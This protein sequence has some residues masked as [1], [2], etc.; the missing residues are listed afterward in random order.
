MQNVAWFVHL[1]KTG[2]S[3]T[4]S[5]L[6]RDSC[7]LADDCAASTGPNGALIVVPYTVGLVRPDEWDDALCAPRLLNPLRRA[8]RRP[9]AQAAHD[10]QNISAMCDGGWL[11]LLPRH[12]HDPTGVSKCPMNLHWPASLNLEIAARVRHASAQPVVIATVRNPLQWYGSSFFHHVRG[13]IPSR[14]SNSTAATDDDRAKSEACSGKFRQYVACAALFRQY[15]A[16][17]LDH[18]NGFVEM[19]RHH[20]GTSPSELVPHWAWMRTET[21]AADMKRVFE[22]ATGRLYP[23]DRSCQMPVSNV[24]MVSDS[25]CYSI[26]YDDTTAARVAS[27]EAWAFARFGYSRTPVGACRDAA[28]GSMTLLPIAPTDPSPHGFPARDFTRGAL[29]NVWS[30]A[31]PKMV[32]VRKRRN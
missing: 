23:A 31:F 5:L 2:G 12:R 10:L 29:Y 20:L 25:S 21:L 8:F 3:S 4:S 19:L 28:N 27:A 6:V 7:R 15:V 17:Q 32:G 22:R 9:P 13:L 16:A 30:N 11:P 14:T 24:G 26:L 18:S 1:P